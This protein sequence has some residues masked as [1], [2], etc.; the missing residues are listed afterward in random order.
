MTA[1]NNFDDLT[2]FTTTFYKDDPV[3]QVREKLAVKLLENTNNFGVKVVV[4]D[5]GSN[6]AFLEKIKLI[7]NVRLVVDPTLTMGESRRKALEIAV[8]ES[9]TPFYMWVEPEK[10]ALI[11]SESL[12]AMLAPLR[13]HEV[14]IVVPKRKSLETLPPLQAKL[15]Q[16]ANKRAGKITYGEDLSDNEVLDMWFGPKLFNEAT[17]SYFTKYNSKLDKWDSVLKPVINAHHDGKKLAGVEVDYE[18]DPSQSGS[19]VNDRKMQMKRLEQYAT[20]LAEMG[21]P[22]WKRKIEDGETSVR[23]FFK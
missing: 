11:T 7:P 6:K 9:H 14:D 10:D 20:I 5:G 22:F 19:E 13:E 16:R 18:Y 8:A 12:E 2:I 15:E 23:K 17:V 3:S 4:V 21:D 1:K